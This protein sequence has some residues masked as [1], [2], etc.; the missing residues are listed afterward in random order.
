MSSGSAAVCVFDSDDGD[1]AKNRNI[2]EL[3]STLRT[4]YRTKDFD[5]VEEILVS[6]EAKLK[7]EMQDM[8]KENGF[9]YEQGEELKRLVVLEKAAQ[10]AAQ[11]GERKAVERYEKL[12]EEVKRGGGR[13]DDKRVILELK[14]KCCVLECAKMK[15][16]SEVEL[17]KRRF[18]ELG[19]RVSKLEEDTAMLMDLQSAGAIVDI[20]DSDDDHAPGGILCREGNKDL[21]DKV[22]SGMLKRKQT[23]SINVSENP[24]G[25][26]HKGDDDICPTSKRK[27]KR[28]E[29]LIRDTDGSRADHCSATALSSGCKNVDELTSS[30]RQC[31]E[32]MKTVHASRNLMHELVLAGDS[33]SS[34]SSSDSDDEFISSRI[35]KL[36]RKLR[37]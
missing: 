9:L 34:F 29:E 5:R 28:Q 37:V 6:R 13:D 7:R 14:K 2:S 10:D 4:A 12:L 35:T 24:N 32:K 22:S 19:I 17:W 36:Q 30:S 26:D 21:I 33:D 15:A 31:E 1:G 20:I 18:K 3:I 27:R 16:E 11:V 23:T 8:K 25:G